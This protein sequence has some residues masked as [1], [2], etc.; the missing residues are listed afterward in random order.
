[1]TRRPAGVLLAALAAVA[2][3]PATA[4]AASP[5]GTGTGLSLARAVRDVGIGGVVGLLVLLVV[6]WAPVRRQAVRSSAEPRP[7]EPAVS[8]DGGR[9]ADLASADHVVVSTSARLLRGLGIA[10]LVASL[11]AFVLAGAVATGVGPG[12]ALRP[13]ALADQAGTRVGAWFLVTAVAFALLALRPRRVVEV[14][15]AARRPARRDGG[16]R[17]ADDGS[18]PDGPSRDHAAALVVALLVLLVVAPA[19]GGSAVSSS[20]SW[21]LVPVHVVHVAGMGAW[22]GGLAALVLVLPRALRTQPEGLPRLGL[23]AAVVR[24]FSP[25]ALVSVAVLTAAGTGLAVLHLT[26]LYDL[27]DTAYGRAIVAKAALLV[28]AIV[29]A[30]GQREYLLPQLR[31]L[32][33]GEA[34]AEVRDDPDSAGSADDAT[35]ASRPD[36]GGPDRGGTEDDEDERRPPSAAAPRYVR[37]ALRA[38]LA[39]LVAVLLVTGALAGYPP[40]RTLDTGSA[41]VVRTAGTATVRATLTPARSGPNALE[42]RVGD[43]AGGPGPD[44]RA[45]RVRAVPPGR[46]GGSDVAMDV[47][48]T[49]DGPGRWTADGVELGT[50]GGWALEV[51]G[52]V[53]GGAPLAADLPV[54]VR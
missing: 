53:P 25:V 44:V 16:A 38:E 31:R 34:P 50:R 6:V 11:V 18:V 15:V 43:A 37:S 17:G 46:S 14:A 28:V 13:S 52:V 22:F 48:V 36:V 1:M 45:L 10:G 41:V 32:A 27:T 54:R 40:P 2:L 8:D 51:R 26:T 7:D 42:I 9:E 19:L 21:A 30:V 5:A 47:R 29:L 49:P 39:L 33:D 4:D 23:Q 3:L 35:P 12:D 20:P 24:R